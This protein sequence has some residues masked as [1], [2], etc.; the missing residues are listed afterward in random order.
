MTLWCRSNNIYRWFVGVKIWCLN[1]KIH[2]TVKAT[3]C[4]LSRLIHTHPTHDVDDI[5]AYIYRD[6]KI[7]VNKMTC[8]RIFA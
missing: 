2:G 1:R 6:N 7:Y 3:R 5:Y 8:G 4:G